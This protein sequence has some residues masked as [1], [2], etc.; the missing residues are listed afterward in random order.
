MGLG[1]IGRMAVVTV[2]GVVLLGM[3]ASG[4]KA[5]EEYS[6]KVH[7]ST[8]SS[9]KEVLVSEDGTTWGKFNIGSGIKPGDTVSLVWDSSTN[10]EDCRQLV[11][12]IFKDGS[13]S[14]P[15][16]F[17]FCEKGLDLEF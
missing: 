4:T 9:I 8:N 5:A 12:A 17:D 16:E 13:E 7:N 6:F 10:N 3:V 15:A 1:K 14:A 11:K 2:L